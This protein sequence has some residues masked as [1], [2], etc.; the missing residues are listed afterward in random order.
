[1]AT[2]ASDD[3]TFEKLSLGMMKKEGK[4]C[5]AAHLPACLLNPCTMRARNGSQTAAAM[6]HQFYLCAMT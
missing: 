3:S 1:M 2:A 5:S 6:Q 4:V